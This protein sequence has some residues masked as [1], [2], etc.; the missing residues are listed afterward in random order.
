VTVFDRLPL[1]SLVTPAAAAVAAAPSP[2]AGAHAA[3][4]RPRP[5]PKAPDGAAVVAQD[6]SEARG[7]ASSLDTAE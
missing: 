7:S 6:G 1:P 2:P 4:V 5:R 3:Q